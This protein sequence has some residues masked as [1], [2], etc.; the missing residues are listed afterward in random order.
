MSASTKQKSWNNVQSEAG[1]ANDKKKEEIARGSG[2]MP[3]GK[4]ESQD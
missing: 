1:I 4:F 2:G 3:L